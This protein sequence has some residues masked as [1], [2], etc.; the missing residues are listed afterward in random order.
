MPNAIRKLLLFAL[1]S[2]LACIIG[3]TSDQLGDVRLLYWSV[4][5]RHGGFGH[6]A[7]TL[8]KRA[9]TWSVALARMGSRAWGS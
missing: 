2:V 3:C 1:P 6:W 4:L 9:G 5:R 8:R 7:R